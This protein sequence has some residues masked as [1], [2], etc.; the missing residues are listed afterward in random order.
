[1]DA[2]ATYRAVIDTYSVVIASYTAAM[3]IYTLVIAADGFAMTTDGAAIDADV[4]RIACFKAKTEGKSPKHLRRRE[5]G[6]T[7]AG[8]GGNESTSG[9]RGR[10]EGSKDG[11]GGSPALTA[12][13]D[14]GGQAAFPTTGGIPRAGGGVITRLRGGA[15]AQETRAK[16]RQ[17]AQR[18]LKAGFH[19]ANQ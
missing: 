12:F 10:K 17:Q 13:V 9:G 14:A 3:S 5:A 16:T 6:G 4:G 2:I 19:R 11:T 1:M 18:D 15:P 7:C 8:K